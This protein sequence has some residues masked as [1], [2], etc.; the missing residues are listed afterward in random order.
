MG[1]IRLTKTKTK[2]RTQGTITQQSRLVNANRK[3]KTI[4][5]DMQDHEED[6]SNTMP[7][8]NSPIVHQRDPP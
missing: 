5:S 2:A 1:V 8:N 3:Q 7:K 4:K 6:C